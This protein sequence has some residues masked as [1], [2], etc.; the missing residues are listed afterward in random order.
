MALAR[1]LGVVLHR[2]RV[3]GTD[4]PWT[5]EASPVYGGEAMFC[6]VAEFEGALAETPGS[7]SS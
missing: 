1:K 3:D 2:M 5:S 4:F 6:T 7:G